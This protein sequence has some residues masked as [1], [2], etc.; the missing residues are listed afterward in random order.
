MLMSLPNTVDFVPAEIPIRESNSGAGAL[1]HMSGT[2]PSLD[3]EINEF[4]ISGPDGRITGI[5]GNNMDK[6]KV[7]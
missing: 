6:I 4:F 1:S 5:A 2:S 3:G 7:I